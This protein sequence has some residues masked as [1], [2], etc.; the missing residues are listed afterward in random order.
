MD[1]IINLCRDA[2]TYFQQR[3]PWKNPE[4][5]DATIYTCVQLVKA[6]SIFINPFVPSISEKIWKI[7]NLESKIE[8]KELEVKIESN[9]LINK[10]EIVIDKIDIEEV[11][12]KYDSLKS[13]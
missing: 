7:L 1:A 2:N 12:K 8:W 5:K 11:K 13:G 9:H 3:E 6:F 10:P 4:K